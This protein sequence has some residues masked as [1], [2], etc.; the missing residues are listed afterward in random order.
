[1]NLARQHWAGWLLL[2]A[3][4][5]APAAEPKKLEIYPPKVELTGPHDQQRLGLL[6]EFAD[7]THRDLSRSAAFTISDP[8]IARIENGVVIPVGDGSATI[9]V[10]AAGLT[11]TLGSTSAFV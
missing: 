4:L 6:A 7:G 3:C 11:A 8:K 10:Q 2:I 5:S 9:A 1:M